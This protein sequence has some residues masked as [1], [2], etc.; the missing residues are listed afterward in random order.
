MAILYDP[1]RATTGR[2]VGFIREDDVFDQNAGLAGAR[3]VLSTGEERITDARGFYEFLEVAAG[4]VTVDAT[5]DGFAPAQDVKTVVAGT[6]NWK[7]M[8]MVRG[9]PS[10]A[11]ISAPPDAGMIII[12]PPDAGVIIEPP[13]AGAI[14]ESPDA[15]V[16]I[17]PADA[18][19]PALAA[20]EDEGCVCVRGSRTFDARAWAALVVSLAALRRLRRRGARAAG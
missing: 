13:D 7:S 6:T 15:G 20:P 1:S 9:A 18:G 10:D 11:G 19:E 17:E 14:I 12:E 2:L 8:A 5:L 4:D 16:I 3:V